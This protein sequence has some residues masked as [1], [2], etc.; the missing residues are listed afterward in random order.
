MSNMI[1]R[2]FKILSIISLSLF[3]MLSLIIYFFPRLEFNKP[4][5]NRAFEVF[6]NVYCIYVSFILLKLFLS[7]KNDLMRNVTIVLNT[8]FLG[9]TLLYFSSYLMRLDPKIQFYD[10]EIK[11][12]SKKNKFERIINQYYVVW[13]NNQKKYFEN[14]VC[15]IGPFRYYIEYDVNLSELNDDWVKME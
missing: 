4:E 5:Y 12:F 2:K 11:Y 7:I 10:V 15:D 3:L 8:L 9:I 1:D 14:R 13:K 6:F